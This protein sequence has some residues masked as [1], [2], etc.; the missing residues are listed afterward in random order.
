[1]EESAKRILSW[2]SPLDYQAIYQENLE[3]HQEGT[4]EWILQR[5]EFVD[6]LESGV[7]AGSDVLL[8]PGIRTSH[9]IHHRCCLKAN[10]LKA[11]AGKSVTAY[12]GL[13]SID[14]ATYG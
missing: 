2:L 4:I 8:C 3:R 6:W 12:D 13:A 5:D 14:T 7:D 9:L 11:G 1:L 10:N